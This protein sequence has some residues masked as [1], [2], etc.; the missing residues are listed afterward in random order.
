[1]SAAKG[2]RRVVLG[3]VTHP[4]DRPD[5]DQPDHRAQPAARP[6]PGLPPAPEDHRHPAVPDPIQRVLPEQHD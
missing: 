3:H 2:L 4:V 6:D 1:V 5:L